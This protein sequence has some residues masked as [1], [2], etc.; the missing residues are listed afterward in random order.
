MALLVSPSALALEFS[1]E[2]IEGDA[3]EN[4]R[5]S[6]VSIQDLEERDPEQLR[7]RIIEQATQG[8]QSIGYYQSEFQ[9]WQSPDQPDKVSLRV[10]AGEP[11]RLRSL[12]LVF[13]GEAGNDPAFT[14]LRELLPLR[15]GEVFHHGRYESLKTEV[16]SLALERGY[17][18]ATWSRHRVVI[19]S[20]Q[21]AADAELVLESGARYRLGSVSFSQ[22]LVRQDMLDALV[23]FRAGAEYDSAHILKLNKN[24]L[25]SR[26]FQ[27][28][29][30]RADHETAVNGVIPVAVQVENAQPNTVDLGIGYSTDVGP[31]VS[32]KWS[33]PLFNEK[34]H[35]VEL[36]GEASSVRQSVDAS[37]IIPWRHPIDD[38]F[39]MLY[40]VQR[41]EVED[42]VTYTTVLG[43]QHQ[44]KTAS[45]WQRNT[46]LRWNRESYELA[47]GEEGKTDL[48]LPGVSWTRTR[49]KGGADPYW[50][51]RQ[52]YQLEASSRSLGSDVSLASARAGW[53]FLRSPGGRHRLF[54]RADL[55]AMGADIY[56]DVPPSQRFF[57]GGD[58]SV[59]GFGYK[60]L[61]PVDADGNVVGGRYLAVGSAEYGYQWTS[62]WR[63]HVF[64][65]VG[66][67]F[68]SP[69][70]EM[71]QGTGFGVAW[72]SPVGPIRLDFAWGI[73]DP[74]TPFRIHFSMGPAL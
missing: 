37:Y 46:Y 45:N 61:G 43:V 34:G 11:V 24:L 41:E 60:T 28:V 6:L 68:D 39:K 58:Q 67:A 40:G 1:I 5:A 71:A 51:D 66:N 13:N 52:F 65:D 69:D 16:Q 21:N 15:E 25:D 27:S 8:M 57:A 56:E 3:L 32:G 29:R 18:D 64:F 33:R 7:A 26:Y 48:V 2:G 23:P 54:F 12:R 4:L 44:T 62:R 63:G 38:T 74:E 35:G 10:S 55:G 42:S 59:R 22:T 14:A 53:R 49:A 36:A 20:R 47:S 70:D 73:S 72:R 19:D 31:R 17:F 50:G 30:V 9:V